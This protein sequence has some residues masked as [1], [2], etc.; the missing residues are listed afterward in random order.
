MFTAISRVISLKWVQHK[1]K[2]KNVTTCKIRNEK[3]P[4]RQVLSCS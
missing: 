3:T 4:E 2:P 1:T